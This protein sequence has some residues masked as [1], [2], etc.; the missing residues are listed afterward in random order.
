[1]TAV[2]RHLFVLALQ[3]KFSLI[4]IK[5]ALIRLA[6][7]PYT[8]AVVASRAQAPIVW[9]VVFVTVYALRRRLAVLG[10]G[11]VALVTLDLGVPAFE[12][13]V[14][15][16][17]I[18]YLLVQQDDDGLPALVFRMTVLALNALDV[19]AEPVKSQPLADISRN[20]LV[21]VQAQASLSGFAEWLVATRTLVFILGVTLNNF[22]RHDETLQGRGCFACRR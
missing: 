20:L 11:C 14:R 17:M 6:P 13:E 4:V 3:R 1:M 19:F 9:I 12:W 5:A 7:R 15:D 18:K 16:R 8:V 21:T 2:A 10:L 22:T